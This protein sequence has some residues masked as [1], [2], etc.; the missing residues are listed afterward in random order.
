MSDGAPF[1]AAWEA[2]CAAFTSAWSEDVALISSL[3][4]VIGSSDSESQLGELVVYEKLLEERVE[5]AREY[6]EKNRK[7]YTALSTAA[8]VMLGLIIL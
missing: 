6:S 5:S 3:G 1:S 7:L 8:G 2:A 4:S